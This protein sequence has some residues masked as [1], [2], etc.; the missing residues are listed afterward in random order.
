[1][2]RKWIYVALVTDRQIPKGMS[3]HDAQFSFCLLIQ[4]LNDDQ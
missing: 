4:E 1:M 2:T 3:S